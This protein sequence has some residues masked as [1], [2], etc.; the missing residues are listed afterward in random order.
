MILQLT[1]V[2]VDLASRRLAKKKIKEFTSLL[3]LVGWRGLKQAPL[4]FLF[5]ARIWSSN[6][7]AMGILGWREKE[8]GMVVD[9]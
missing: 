3:P 4:F 1:A 2:K 6:G 7:A 9:C 8:R 5:T